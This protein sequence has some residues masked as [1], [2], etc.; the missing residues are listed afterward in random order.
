M[1]LTQIFGIF[2]MAAW[3]VIFIII[4]IG[5]NKHDTRKIKRH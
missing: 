5:G 1:T 4:L 3:L 2:I